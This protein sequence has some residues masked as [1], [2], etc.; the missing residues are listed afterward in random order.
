MTHRFA[1]LCFVALAGGLLFGACSDSGGSKV[2]V[3]AGDSSCEPAKTDLAAG[4]IT[5]TAKNEGSDVTE[6]YVLAEGDQIRGEV[7]NVAP[8][9]SRDLSVDLTAGEYTLQCKPGQQGDGI[10]T[11]ITVTGS[12]GSAA[13]EASREIEIDAKEYSYSGA[14]QIH[15]VKGETVKLELKNEGTVEHEMEVFG[16][17][18][19]DLGEVG[20]T[21]AGAQGNVTITFDKSGTYVLKCGIEDHE[22]KGMK[23]SFTVS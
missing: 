12:G 7:E 6:L 9:T 16:P 13:K 1:S 21:K 4:K 8:G 22:T 2:V 18:G 17:N 15:G 14:D 5:F 3:R 10:R 11:K 20:P 23:A 19:E